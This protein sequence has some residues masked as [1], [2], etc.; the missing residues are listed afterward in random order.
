MALRYSAAMRRRQTLP[1]LWLVSDARNDGVL[2]Q[3]LRALPRGS[4]LV[5]RHYHLA[6]QA[7]AARF[8]ALL[9]ICRQRGLVAIWAGSARAARRQGADGC[10]GAAARIGAGPGLLRLATVHT[11]R[12]I[13]QAR[14]ADA[15]LL[16]P[17]FATRSHPG[18]RAL[19]PARF[20]LLARQ[21]R[22]P[23]LALGGMNRATARRLPGCGWAAI[24]GLSDRSGA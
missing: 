4:G 2:E 21:A 7:R 17:V 18:G 11:L 15:L 5:Y 8:S 6:P 24:D 1:P 14:R 3:A 22:L 12:E 10:Y 16:S 13:A 9:R 20:L 19:G 23:V